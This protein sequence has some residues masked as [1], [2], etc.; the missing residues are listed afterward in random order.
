MKTTPMIPAKD[1]DLTFIAQ[2]KYNKRKRGNPA[3]RSRRQYLDIVTAFDIETSHHPEREESLLYI[4]QWQFGD[5]VTAYGRTWDELRDFM[6]RLIIAI[7]KR[8]NAALVVLVHNLSYE[9]QFLRGVYTFHREEVFAVD[10]RRV[11]KCTM[12]DKR[13]EFRDTYL[14][15]NMSL[16]MYCKKM[17]VEHQ[18]LSGEEFDYN[19]L[20]FPD[21]P[22]TERQL[23]YCQN[24]VIG[25]VEAY[26]AE[27]KRDGDNLYTIP[28]TSTG[29][30]RKDCKRAMRFV[31]QSMIRKLQPD[32][33][34]YKMLREAFRGG[35]THAN[36]HFAGKIIDN[37]HSAD[38]S[39]SY[40]DVMCNCKFPMGRFYPIN[41]E[42]DRA[43]TLYNKGYALLIRVRL[44]D[45]A[46]SDPSWGFPYISFSRC[47]NVVAPTL[48]NGR[49][50]YAEYLETT[51]TDIDL[52]II[53]DQYEFSDIELV[54]GYFS[55]YDRL[56]A[57]LIHCTIDYYQ[58][59]TR[60][61]G[62]LDDSGHET[63]IYGK[64]KALLNSLYGMMATDPCKQD[65]IFDDLAEGLFVQDMQPLEDLV[66]ANAKKAFICYQW[67][68]WVTAWARLRLQ[69]GLK[70]ASSGDNSWPV[71]CDTDSVKYIGDVDWSAYNKKRIADSKRSGAFAK[72]PKGTM[73]YMGVFEQED[74][75]KQ[76][77]TLGAKKYV[78]VY[79]DG[80]CHC[81]IAGVNKKAG[82]EEL[83]KHGGITAFREGFTFVDAGG[84]ESVYN[85]DVLPH[86]EEWN[87]HTFEMVPNILIRESTYTI[88]VTGDYR[89]I[90]RDPDFYLQ[91]YHR[92]RES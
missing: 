9:F 84:T 16:A 81:T 73:H 2:L 12:H 66:E 48:D 22:L 6:R 53:L 23:Q 78:T 57:P 58:S 82:G 29:Y 76:F 19:A 89:D 71:Y 17:N 67:G 59:K 40:P 54:T 34:L 8:D 7:D 36:R 47:R 63:P 56:P 39:S 44:W 79:E 18:K 14:H 21:T 87:G 69:E 88:G 10:A 90:L 45:I 27:M 70:L 65:I 92:F 52:K 50:L 30:V 28:Y 74:T 42:I 62:V 83:D 86:M 51:I 55:R 33:E 35:D 72:D 77:K 24:D 11:L 68:V 49:I 61:K 46:M 3:S 37:V 43:I 5:I 4:W 60:L 1:V 32:V 20:R 15:S 91:L 75:A 41:G 85:D 38:R 64:S 25:L 13:L 26:T 31:S 80:E